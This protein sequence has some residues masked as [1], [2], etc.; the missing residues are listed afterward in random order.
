MICSRQAAC[1]ASGSECAVG[2][3]GIDT[4]VQPD[5]VDTVYIANG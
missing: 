2:V 4:C 5:G 3:Y 1:H